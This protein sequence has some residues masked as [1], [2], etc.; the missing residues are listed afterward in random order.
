MTVRLVVARPNEKVG[1]RVTVDLR[2]VAAGGVT[3]GEGSIDI[4]LQTISFSP[5]EENMSPVGP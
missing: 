3:S 5:R 1:V 4:D 2:D